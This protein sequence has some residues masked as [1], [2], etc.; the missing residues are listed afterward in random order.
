MTTSIPH[1]PTL[2]DAKANEAQSRAPYAEAL[3]KH[4]AKK[5]TQ[6]MVPGHS[7]RGDDMGA[8]LASFFGERAVE[9]DL[10]LMLNGIDLGP[11]SPMQEAQQLAAEAWGA[12]R[13]WFMTNGASQANRTAAVAARGLG[14]RVLVQRNSHSS[15]S[16]GILLTG[17]IPRF[18]TPSIDEEHGISHGVTPSEIAAALQSAVEEDRPIAAVY[19]VSPS[20]FGSVSDVNRIAEVCHRYEAALIVDGAW[21]AHFGFHE[22]LPESPV[23]LGADLVISS[24][25]KLAG[26]F[27]QSAMLH[28]GYGPFAD[29]LETLIQRGVN[30]TASTSAS[31]LLMGS[32]DIARQSMVAETELIGQSIE[33]AREFRELVEA[34]G[35]FSLIDTG[36]SEFGDIVDNDLLRVAIDVSKLGQSGH[37]VR[38]RLIEDHS[39]YF[40]MATATTIVAVLGAGHL[41]PIADIMASLQAV[42]DEAQTLPPATLSFPPLPEPGDLRTLP[43]D[44][45][46]GES[47][48]VSA[49]EAVG[50]ISC[51]S[52]AAY[53]PGIPNLIPGEEITAETVA[54]LQAV[55]TSPTG[56]VRGA[57]DPFVTR[58]R[59]R[60]MYG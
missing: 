23:R 50:R 27:T 52:L 57:V 42:A 34:D 7:G 46:F 12:K 39:V 10:P 1:I 17:L 20:Y 43:R 36:F 53:P 41:H 54:F 3:Q 18:I 16:D 30:M 55:A 19:I 56:Y 8:R 31:A 9:L 11:D 59:V 4:V 48:I 28:L 21:G 38:D 40:E 26:S 6:I 47:E 22:D 37:W 2:Q 14:E 33:L 45:Y 29:E 60:R 44:A 24:T 32:L 35:R 15:F 5:P 51:D 49:D 25:H 58:F 13:T